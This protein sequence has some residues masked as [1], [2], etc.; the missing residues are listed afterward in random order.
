MPIIIDGWNFIRNKNSNISDDAN[1][2]L[3]SAQALI[4]YLETFQSSHSDPV[5][6]VFDSKR[7]F[8]G[9]DYKNSRKLTVV[10]T[11][12]AD[13]YIKRYIDKMPES[14]RRNLRVVSS[15]NDVYYYA[16]SSYAMPLKCEEFWDKLYKTQM[17]TSEGET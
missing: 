15:D 6:V 2:A 11:T 13:N 12:D 17:N 1:D 8:L 16:R 5:I 3:E 4:A 7:E 9:L 10:P 14:Q